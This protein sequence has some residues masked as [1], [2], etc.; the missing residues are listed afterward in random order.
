[1][2]TLIWRL[3][4]DEI[5]LIDDQLF[6]DFVPNEKIFSFSGFF[7]SKQKQTWLRVWNVDESKTENEDLDNSV[8]DKPFRSACSENRIVVLIFV[9]E[10]NKALLCIRDESFRKCWVEKFHWQIDFGPICRRHFSDL[11]KIRKLSGKVLRA[12][13]S[14]KKSTK[15]ILF[16]SPSLKLISLPNEESFVEYLDSFPDEIRRWNKLKNRSIFSKNSFQS[17]SSYLERTM[18]KEQQPNSLTRCKPT[19]WNYKRF[20]PEELF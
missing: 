1:M 19:K 6:I 4:F 17:S 2:L 7:P 20:V 16:F 11:D 15:S 8:R 10:K 5:E 14:F 12:D 9:L 18:N 13:R 3:L